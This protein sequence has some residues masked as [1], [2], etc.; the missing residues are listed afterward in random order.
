MW[1][2]RWILPLLLALAALPWA[3]A[4]AQPACTFTLGFKILRD[5]IAGIVGDFCR[6]AA[7]EHGSRGVDCF[8]WA[9]RKGLVESSRLQPGSGEVA[10]RATLALYQGCVQA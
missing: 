6:Q 2:P 7:T 4:R 5:Q 3:P 9:F 10:A 8:E 1:L